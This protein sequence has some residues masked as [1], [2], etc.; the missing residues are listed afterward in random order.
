[1]KS[2]RVFWILTVLVASAVVMAVTTP[3]IEL[4]PDSD[5]ELNL[6]VQLPPT[7]KVSPEAPISIDITAE[8]DAIAQAPSSYK[9]KGKDLPYAIKFKTAAA[10]EGLL[11]V[12]L[13]AFVCQKDDEGVCQR[14]KTEVKVPISVKADAPVAYDLPV[15]LTPQ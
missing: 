1:M 11:T 8:G 5:V 14:L 6:A 2:N 13:W 4:S 9:G 3:V 12:S 15:A 10:G 7:H